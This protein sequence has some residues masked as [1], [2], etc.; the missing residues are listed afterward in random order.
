VLPVYTSSDVSNKLLINGK[1]M[2]SKRNNTKSV[3]NL[4]TGFLSLFRLIIEKKLS[5]GTATSESFMDH[6]AW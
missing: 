4:F 1:K 2:I 5:E 3:N 6:F